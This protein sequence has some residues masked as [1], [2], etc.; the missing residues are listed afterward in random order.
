MGFLIK[1]R[2]VMVSAAATRSSA[3]CLLLIKRHTVIIH[4]YQQKGTGA[5]EN[6]RFNLKWTVEVFHNLPHIISVLHYF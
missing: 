4:L 6:T 2:M 3:Y 1:R 5:R